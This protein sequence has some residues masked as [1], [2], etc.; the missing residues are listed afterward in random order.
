MKYF[1]NII[2]LFLCVSLLL[3]TGCVNATPDEPVTEQKKNILFG[4]EFP[5][6]LYEDVSIE[7]CF[8][9]TGEYPEDASYEPCENVVAL[10]VKNTAQNDIQLLRIR[11]Q[12]ES[13][14]LIFE[15][16]TLTAG[17]TA[18]VLE[19]SKQTLSENEVITS[20]SGGNRADFKSNVSLMSETFL[21]QGNPQT[22]NI[23]NISDKDIDS[24]I[25]IYY[26]KKDS[27]GNFFGGITFRAKA[28]GL[29]A[30]EIK[31][32][33]ASKFNPDD[34]QVMFIDYVQQ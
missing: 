14:E 10:K 16:T 11:V 20:F 7:D 8:L 22:I 26:K 2:A 6:A 34:S 12:T 9:Y 19:K 28:E 21:V 33:P 17:S 32:L 5:V 30:G 15:I 1:K 31:Q 29:K 23:K 3:L 25:Y 13:K 27:Q 24:D 4:Y 18:I